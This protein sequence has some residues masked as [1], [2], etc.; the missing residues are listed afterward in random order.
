M[1]PSIDLPDLNV[2]LALS[3]AGHSHHARATAYWNQQRRDMVGFC[4]VTLIGLPRLL[5]SS[6]VMLGNPFPPAIAA[7]KTRG[8]L[9]LPDVRFLPDGDHLFLQMGA[10]AKEPFFT[11]KLW[12]DAWIAAL[13]LEY[14]CRVVSFDAD[15]AK[16]PGL[17]FLHLTP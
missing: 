2:W 15:F 1:T 17:A 7:G 13:A 8:F 5:T 16:F 6:S 14:N 10:W 9:N 11:A 12:T 4:G 3:F